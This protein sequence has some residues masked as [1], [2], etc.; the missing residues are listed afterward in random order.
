MSQ[1]ELPDLRPRQI[2]AGTVTV[3][4]I[5]L[6]FWLL[7]RFHQVVI[8]F[9]AALV[10]STAIQPL[11][12]RLHRYGLPRPVSVVVV[13]LFFLAGVAGLIWALAPVALSQITRLA[14]T[15]P[16]LYADLRDGMLDSGSFF[17]WR[18]GITLPGELPLVGLA[19]LDSDDVTMA[20]RQALDATSL[21]LKTIFVLVALLVLTFYWTLDGQRTIRSLLLWLPL[22]YREN[23]RSFLQEAEARVAAFITGQTILCFAIGAMALVAYWLLDLPYAL[24]L[25]IL[26]G[27]LE[28]VPYLGPI[29]AAIPAIIVGYSVDPITAVW[30]LAVTTVIQ[31]LE[32]NVLAPRVMR[33]SVGVHPMVTLLAMTAF[34]LLFGVAGALVAIPLAAVVQLF[35]ER[36]IIARQDLP[37]GRDE[38]SVL[39]YDTQNLVQDIRKRI[40]HK[41]GAASGDSDQ[42]ED[43]LEMIAAS[44]DHL[45]AVSQQTTARD[46]ATS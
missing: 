3:I 20:A 12:R 38:V 9:F 2:V 18:L 19:P 27:V 42:L 31:Q 32:G 14:A 13:Y 26:T 36:Y 22:S 46:Q 6:A 45:L 39:R 43:S 1:I 17:F 16:D 10:I 4:A 7:Y 5:A 34:G 29:M 44:L 35:F 24:G 15:L 28:L 33:R 30:V 37:A 21:L 40:R 8:I 23:V 41:D 11:T 25:A